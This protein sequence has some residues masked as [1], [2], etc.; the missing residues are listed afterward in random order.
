MR[1][2]STTGGRRALPTLATAVFLCGIAGMWPAAA[3]D[4]GPDFGGADSR[5]GYRQY[6]DDPDDRRSGLY[7]Y[8]S[9]IDRLGREEFERGYRLGRDDERFRGGRRGGEGDD[10]SSARDRFAG[11]GWND[12]WQSE[13]R[14]RLERA[15]ARLREALVLML[16]QPSGRGL[17]EAS[18]QA[19]QALIRVQNAMTWLPRASDAGEGED[20]RRYERR[21]G[22]GI[23]RYRASGE[24]R[25]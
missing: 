25:N 17:D 11:L 15:A 16:R 1:Q 10:R 7:G 23:G 19:R 5:Y 18:D 13:P 21:S 12:P 4:R 8:R 2:H 9:D 22:Q 20:E 14:E 3:Q 6:G 24:W